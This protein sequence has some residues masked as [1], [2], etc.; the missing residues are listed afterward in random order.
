MSDINLVRSHSLSIAKAK[1]LVQKAADGRATE[2]HVE[3]EWHGN[4]L[5]FHRSGVD[6][7]MV[8]TESEIEL[9]ITLG[10]LMERFQGKIVDRIKHD[11]D[12]L[13]A[14]EG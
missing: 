13:L 7:Q 2:Y 3:S 12:K 5:R 6:G 9:N 14:E 4:T 8:V 1:A 11:L 10:R